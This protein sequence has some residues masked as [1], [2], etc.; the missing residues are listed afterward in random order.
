MY[1]SEF[2]IQEFINKFKSECSKIQIKSFAKNEIITTYIEKR[3]QI[4]I[5]ISGEADLI[6]Y[7]LNG[8]K[9]IIGHFEKNQV[10]GELFYPTNTNNEL[11]VL[12][13]E[14]SE[15]LFFMYDDILTKCKRNCPFHQELSTGLTK[16]ILNEIV[17]LNTRIELLTKRNIRD[18]LVSY[19]NLLSSKTLYKTITIP[20]SYTDLADYLSIDRS[21]MS[22]EL[23][24]LEDENFIKRNGKK[25]T[26]LYK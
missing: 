5:L 11:F 22:R 24:S 8:T 7:D 13:K 18:K 12:T 21:A 23:K 26:L 2:N 6:R 15:V 20:F 16:L 9:T 4:C 19:F 14:N 25:I 17:D 3:N 1:I 10:F